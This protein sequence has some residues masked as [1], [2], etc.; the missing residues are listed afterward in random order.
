MLAAYEA[1]NAPEGEK[2]FQLVF[3]ECGLLSWETDSP[4]VPQA[5]RDY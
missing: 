4:K 3:P 5:R 1:G 2:D